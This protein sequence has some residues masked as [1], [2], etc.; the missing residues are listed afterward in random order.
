MLTVPLLRRRRR[1][2]RRPDP[3]AAGPMARSRRLG[4]QPALAAIGLG[5]LALVA[6]TQVTGLANRVV[7]A[8]RDLDALRKERTYLEASIGRLEQEWN[9]LT[10][11]DS[12]VQRASRDLG[13]VAPQAPGTLVVVTGIPA[14]AAAPAWAR[15]L[16]A[17]GG[18]GAAVPA[19]AAGEARRP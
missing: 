5:A 18:G 13:L 10:A 1:A 6:L 17:V 12:V 11:R 15:V 4:G 19:A 7:S 16:G 2:S 8:R 9:R 14:T 3:L